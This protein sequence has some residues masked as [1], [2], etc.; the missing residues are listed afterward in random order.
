MSLFLILVLGGALFFAWRAIAELRARVQ[1]L[2][3]QARLQQ[4][5]ILGD[6]I[7]RLT[8]LEG[9]VRQL[10]GQ[11][12]S[13][14]GTAA[15]APP[16][17]APL[18]VDETAPAAAAA[19]RAAAEVLPVAMPAPAMPPVATSAPPETAS[20]AVPPDS[21][22]WEVVV[23]TSWLNKI[24]VLVFVVGVALLVGYSFTHIGPLG[25]VAMG[26]ALSLAMLAAGVV[27]ERRETY[28]NYAYGLI[29]GGWAGI[30]FTAFAM[31][32]VPAA[33]VVDNPAIATALLLAIS[34]GMIGHSLRY[35]A[36]TVTALAYIAAYAALVL[37]PLSSFALLASIPLALSVLAVAA[38]LQWPGVALLGVA[39]T[40]TLFVLRLDVLA[41]A[42]IAVDSTLPLLT[43][44]IYWLMFE[45]ADIAAARPRGS[46]SLFPLNAVGLI[47]AASLQ[48]PVNDPA[49]MTTFT[50]LASAGYLVSAIVRARLAAA[51]A[52]EDTGD[53]RFGTRH[54]ALALAVTLA[55]WSID[56]RFSANAQTLALL[57]LAELVIVAGLALRDRPIR[58]I[59]GAALLLTALHGGSYALST[60]L[61]TR[62]GP[63]LL[64]STT[65]VAVLVALACWLNR[66]IVRARRL[67]PALIERTYTWIAFVLVSLVLAHE[68]PGDDWPM[69]A[70]AFA[71]VLLEAGLRRSASY[72]FQSY[73]A[74]AFAGLMLMTRY[75][76]ETGRNILDATARLPASDAW[77]VIMATALLL[78]AAWL[79]LR[80]QSAQPGSPVDP[81]A[82][83]P[84]AAG[85]AGFG[86]VLLVWHLLPPL[87]VA[88]VWAAIALGSTAAGARTAS[89]GARWQGY[90][91]ATAAVLRAS[92]A[93]VELEAAS[94][95][96]LLSAIVVI[97]AAYATSLVPRRAIAAA[98]APGAAN[99][100][101]AGR[102][103][104]SIAATL[105]LTVL[106]LNEAPLRFVTVGWGLEGLA[107]F[108]A[109]FGLRD[110]VLRL[111]GLGVLA[112]CLLKLSLS[113]LR[114]LEPLARIV[115]FIV[116]GLVL[117]LVSWTYTRYQE[118]IRRLL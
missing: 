113:D 103:V 21:E 33:R 90:L 2:E 102:I 101:P 98:S 31:H 73:L 20:E 48:L 99:A 52:G 50:A 66:E 96:A 62:D 40:Y 84:V 67:T 27:A 56:L 100:E 79:R 30:Y 28:R 45:I 4:P 5:A 11:K 8:R 80:Q 61:L 60:A 82:A 14:A 93:I 53:I 74:G 16:T 70:A 29:A 63:T 106:I 85:L 7:A 42:S 13:P 77:M 1:E 26:F 115:S 107:L 68:V 89:A 64:A 59:G 109:G 10:G 111:S 86:V 112:A 54:A 69:A 38:R 92:S 75:L 88:P 37:V 47:G 116:L 55:A 97:A 15:H 12:A 25:R 104:T 34:A 51:P 24:G 105:L 41:D 46:L 44:G 43:L 76:A 114:D 9:E 65:P 3:A 19:G 91:L 71:I 118:Q 58:V 39:S 18:E 94:T 110:R 95:A 108:A 117:L 32:A 57:T 35:R 23:G 87:G 6:L 49:T 17:A 83:A 72:R 81:A 78:T 22:A 36:Q